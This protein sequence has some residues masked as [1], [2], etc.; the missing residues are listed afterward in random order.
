MLPFL[1]KRATLD[2]SATLN[3]LNW[4]PT[5]MADSFKTMAAAISK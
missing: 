2:N 1:G 5:P 4:K 3:V